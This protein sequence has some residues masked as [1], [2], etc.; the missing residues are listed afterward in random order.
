MRGM[1]IVGEVRVGKKEPKSI[2]LTK[3]GSA[4]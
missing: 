2:Y 1:A 4:A 3:T